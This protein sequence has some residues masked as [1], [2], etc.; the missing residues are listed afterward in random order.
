MEVDKCLDTMITQGLRWQR[1]K[2]ARFISATNRIVKA[3]GF[4]WIDQ[5]E[6]APDYKP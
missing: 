2:P 5:A 3:M 6:N 4:D 1:F